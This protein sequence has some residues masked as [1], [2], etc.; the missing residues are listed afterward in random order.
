MR[1]VEVFAGVL[2]ELVPAAGRILAEGARQLSPDYF[3]TLKSWSAIG[4][5]FVPRLQCFLDKLRY[6]AKKQ[7][8]RL[9]YVWRLEWVDGLVHAHLLIRTGANLTHALVE[10]LWHKTWPEAAG[11][12]YCEP[13]R[14]SVGSAKYVAKAIGDERK[15]QPPPADYT[16]RLA[17]H[18]RGYLPAKAKD[19]WRSLVKRWY[20]VAEDG[21]TLCIGSNSEIP[22]PIDPS[23]EAASRWFGEQP[24][25]CG[26]D[27]DHRRAILIGNRR[28]E[29]RGHPE[30]RP[31]AVTGIA[32]TRTPIR[33]GSALLPSSGAQSAHLTGRAAPGEMLAKFAKYRLETL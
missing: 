15:T 8:Q 3:L 29:D 31:C 32:P 9:E 17:D 10:A 27:A 14:T 6:Q 26:G 19:M 25:D 11:R 13:V 23:P 1:L 20:P 2:P 4:E 30:D 28:A 21:D 24:G 33:L 12:V 7:G 16:G 18:S 5:D 22:A